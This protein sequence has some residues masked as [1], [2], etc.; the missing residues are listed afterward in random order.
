MLLLLLFVYKHVVIFCNKICENK[1]KINNP[2]RHLNYLGVQIHVCTFVSVKWTS[3]IYELDGHFL[4][5]DILQYLI[6]Q[7]ITESHGL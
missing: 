7:S 6:W 4:E 3:T 2:T 1:F 5:H